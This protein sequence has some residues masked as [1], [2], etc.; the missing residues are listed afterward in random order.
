MRKD[1]PKLASGRSPDWA[2]FE[3]FVVPDYSSPEADGDYMTRWR[4]IQTPWFG[5]FLHRFEM[6]DPRQTLHDHP[7][8]F[9]SI[10]LRGGYDEFRR[11]THIYDPCLED[12]RTYCYP[13]SVKRFSRM[14]LNSLHFIAKL[15]RNPTWTLV[16]VGPRK[17]IWG[18]LDRDG[19]LTDFLSHP[20]NAGF[21]DAMARRAM[22]AN[23]VFQQTESGFSE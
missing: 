20:H 6:P 17:R 12:S 9:F 21:M 4:L 13:H 1:N 11:D 8:A 18:Y 7:W 5:I 15:H 19:K 3:K 14:P 16:F 2:L 23:K 22:R 10:V